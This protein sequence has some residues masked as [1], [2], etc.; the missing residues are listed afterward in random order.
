MGGA[1]VIAAAASLVRRARALD[2]R[3]KVAV[4][5]GGSRG[6]GLLMA[7]ELGRQGAHVAIC[8]RDAAAVSRAERWLAAHG[9]DVVAQA[10]DISDPEAA[11]SFVERIVRELGGIDILINNAGAIHVAPLQQVDV[12]MIEESMR[13]NFWSAVNMTFAALPHLRK[14][15]ANARIV[16]VTSIGGRVPI[17]HMLGYTASK[18]AMVGMSE[19][20]RAE[21]SSVGIKVTTVVPGPMRTGGFYNAE[22]CG[23]QRQEFAWFS[24]LS[25]LPIISVDAERA[26]RRIIRAAREGSAELRLGLSGHLLSFLHGI[27]PRLFVQMSSWLNR[28]LPPPAE[29][30][31]RWK[32]RE[33]NS[34]LPG[35]PVLRLGDHAARMNNEEPPLHR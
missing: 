34:T 7:E 20:L 15:G 3:G 25:S 33:V 2:L 21:L 5:T 31:E 27:A 28:F 23:H 1:S 29:T 26:A 14:H 35:T 8:G 32:G 16:N 30:E 11:K 13:S 12:A 24:V 10:V 19:G 6:L 22:F 9:I 4:V 18:F 17:P